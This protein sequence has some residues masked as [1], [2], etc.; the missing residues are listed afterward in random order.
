MGAADSFVAIQPR[1]PR[2]A[3][4]SAVKLPRLAFLA[5]TS[6]KHSIVFHPP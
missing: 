3:D 4:G 5:M 6:E 2:Q 1:L